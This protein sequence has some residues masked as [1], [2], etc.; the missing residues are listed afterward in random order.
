MWQALYPSMVQGPQ[1]RSFQ[2]GF[3]KLTEVSLF[4]ADDHSAQDSP[5]IYSLLML[6]PCPCLSLSLVHIPHLLYTGPQISRFHLNPQWDSF[7]NPHAL[8]PGSCLHEVSWAMSVLISSAFLVFVLPD[9]Q[10]PKFVSYILSS[11]SSCK[12]NSTFNCEKEVMVIF[13]GIF[14]TVSFYDGRYVIITLSLTTHYLTPAWDKISYM[15]CWLSLG[16][17]QS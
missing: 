12:V 17:E 7:G 4:I 8:A 9:V 10:D 2:G 6:P 3:I 5:W 11:F 1:R 16:D 13:L 15:A 14:T